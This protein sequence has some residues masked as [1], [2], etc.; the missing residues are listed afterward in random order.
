LIEAINLVFPHPL[1]RPD[2][3]CSSDGPPDALSTLPRVQPSLLTLDDLWSLLDNLLSFGQDQL[4]VARVR[5]VRVDLR[6]LVHAHLQCLWYTYTTVGTVCAA[7]LLGS[8]VDLDVLDDQVA[9]VKTLGVGVGLGVLEEC[10]EVLSRLDW[11]ACAGDTELLALTYCQPTFFRIPTVFSV[12][13]A[14]IVLAI[15]DFI[16]YPEQHDR[17]HQHSASL[18][19]LPCARE[20]C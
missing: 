18:G 2:N 14:P 13:S 7:A 9:G 11:P 3:L 15:E 17:F 16:T 8:L 5:H 20:H 1:L 4:D 10:E 19:R 6:R 12:P